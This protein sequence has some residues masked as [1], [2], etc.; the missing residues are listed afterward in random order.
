MYPQSATIF[1][2]PPSIDVL[3]Q[4]LEGRGQDSDDIIQRRMQDAV[5]E[6]SHCRE[7][8]YLIVND[9]FNCAVSALKSIVIAHRLKKDRQLTQLAGLVHALE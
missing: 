3:R 1:I 4:R 8:E 5:S 7:F 2:L 6:M 9:D